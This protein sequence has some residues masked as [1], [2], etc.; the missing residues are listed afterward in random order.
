MR[1]R[2][3]IGKRLPVAGFLFCVHLLHVWY[4][5]ACVRRR[6]ARLCS[7]RVVV[8]NEEWSSPYVGDC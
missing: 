3:V 2:H 8:L 4:I 5:V 7:R 1:L 6:R